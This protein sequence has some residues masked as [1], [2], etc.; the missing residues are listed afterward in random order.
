MADSLPTK[1]L[2]LSSRIKDTARKGRARDS[3]MSTILCHFEGVLTTE[4]S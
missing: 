4:K 2:A 3:V 1:Y